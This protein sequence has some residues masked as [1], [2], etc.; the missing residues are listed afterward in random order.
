M[1]LSKEVERLYGQQ[2]RIRV[3][4]ICLQDSKLL[5]V[6]HRG[7]GP[8][9]IFWAPPGGGMEFGSTAPENL[10]REFREETGLE[11]AVGE[12]MFAHE[13]LQA[14]LH[15]L[16]LFFMV[17]L[18]GGELK[19]GHDPESAKDAQ[20]IEQVSFLSWQQINA[21][22]AATLHQIFQHTSSAEGLLSRRGYYN[23]SP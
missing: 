22:P 8:A 21:L 7:L 12:F 11:V 10:R 2:L 9:G 6:R 14:P 16:E 20:L 18:L 3:C 13:Y 17:S 4:G 1:E 15:A 23:F 5:L 19:R